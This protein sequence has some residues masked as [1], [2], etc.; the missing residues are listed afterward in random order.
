VTSNFD[1]DAG[2][3]AGGVVWWQLDP[4]EQMLIE[5]MLWFQRT[6][7]GSV[8]VTHTVAVARLNVIPPP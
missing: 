1:I 8:K 3:F 2:S 5:P 6:G 4:T 7:D